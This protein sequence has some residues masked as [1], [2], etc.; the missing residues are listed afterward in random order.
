MLCGLRG[1]CE[2]VVDFAASKQA[3]VTMTFALTLVPLITVL[4]LTLDFNRTEGAAQQV[5]FAMDGAVLAAAREL[6]QDSN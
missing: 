1:L 6:Q 3:N 5:Q 2:A 4:G